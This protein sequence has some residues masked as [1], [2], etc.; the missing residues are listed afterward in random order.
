M[1]KHIERIVKGF[2]VSNS[3][4]LYRVITD[5]YSGNDYRVVKTYSPEVNHLIGKRLQSRHTFRRAKVTELD[6]FD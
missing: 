6:Q 1:T 3:G 5:K 2:Y 4:K